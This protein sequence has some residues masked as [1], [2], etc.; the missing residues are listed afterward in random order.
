METVKICIR[1]FGSFRRLGESVSVDVPQNT[2]IQ[3]LK[4]ILTEKLGK[5]EEKLI[6]DS[7][8]ADRESILKK[9]FIL[10]QDTILSI[11]PPVC[12]G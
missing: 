1:F 8:F 7:A 11:L 5:A 4:K 3:T 9:D 10:T 2:D 12:G 6:H